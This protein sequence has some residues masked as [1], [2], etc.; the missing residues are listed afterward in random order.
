MHLLKKKLRNL[1]SQLLSNFN[2]K[3]MTKDRLISLDVFRGLTILLMTIVN[4]PGS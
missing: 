4:N 1:E 2:Q 3:T